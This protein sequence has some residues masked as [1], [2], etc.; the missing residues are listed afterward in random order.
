MLSARP[1]LTYFLL[2][3]SLNTVR[4]TL[5]SLHVGTVCSENRNR[6]TLNFSGE[7]E[8]ACYW[9]Q[10][11]KTLLQAMAETLVA[12]NK[13]LFCLLVR[14]LLSCLISTATS[15]F[16]YFKVLVHTAEFCVCYVGGAS[17]RICYG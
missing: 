17:L 14:L 8:G 16:S 4:H 10:K 13:F 2:A 11:I 7:Q 6:N 12:R 9:V 15:Y 5:R 3:N 1:F